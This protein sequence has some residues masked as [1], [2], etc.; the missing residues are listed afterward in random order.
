M[1][2]FMFIYVNTFSEP[3]AYLLIKTFETILTSSLSDFVKTFYKN[4]KLQAH[5]KIE[6]II[7]F[8]TVMSLLFRELLEILNPPRLICKKISRFSFQQKPIIG[9]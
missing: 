1:T 7:A 3:V 6:V 9:A 2:T 4:N 5:I 8:S